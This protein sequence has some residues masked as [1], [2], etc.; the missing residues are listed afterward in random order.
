[1]TKL[2]RTWVVKSWREKLTEDEMREH[3]NEIDW[4]H[5]SS[6]QKLSE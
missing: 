2:E 1:M 6:E 3:A 4:Y 5:I